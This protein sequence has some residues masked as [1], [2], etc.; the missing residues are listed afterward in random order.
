[1]KRAEVIR[2]LIDETGLNTKAFAKKAGLPYTTLRSMLERGM[3]KSA[4]ENVIKVCGALG[5]AVE[6][7]EQMVNTAH[8]VLFV[9]PETTITNK[10]NIDKGLSSLCCLTVT[11]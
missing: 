4:V 9:H 1:M 10:P 3:S 6:D 11:R 7:M 5:I 2:K 8:A